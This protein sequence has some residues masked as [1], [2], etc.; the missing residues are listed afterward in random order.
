MR[1]EVFDALPKEARKIREEVFVNEQGFQE[2]FDNIDEQ[3]KHV[4]IFDENIAIATCRYYYNFSLNAYLV[5]RIAVIKAYRG[6]KIGALLMQA[7]Q[8]EITK[9]G[10]RKMLV[11]AQTR[12][13]PF[14]E[15]QGFTA[16]GKEDE[17]EGCPHIWMKKE[18]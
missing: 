6:K 3:A 8:A 5:G 18:W 12:A 2:E 1:I 10:A 15:K 13:Q 9:M 4:L 7:A 16:F 14:Y 17:E 11:H